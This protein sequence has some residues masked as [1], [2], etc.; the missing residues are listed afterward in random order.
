MTFFVIAVIIKNQDLAKKSYAVHFCDCISAICLSVCLADSG[1]HPFKITCLQ[2]D[3]ITR[4]FRCQI[5]RSFGVYPECC[6]SE[7]VTLSQ[8]MDLNTQVWAPLNS[9]QSFAA[10]FQL[11]HTQQ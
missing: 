4:T 3:A 2:Q 6:L 5:V 8:E 7:V 11:S 1:G 9:T 10:Y